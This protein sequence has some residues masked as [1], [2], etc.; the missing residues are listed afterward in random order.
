MGIILSSRCRYNDSVKTRVHCKQVAAVSGVRSMVHCNPHRQVWSPS[1]PPG[2]AG[3]LITPLPVWSFVLHESTT[4]SS[5]RPQLPPKT[6]DY[7]RDKKT[8]SHPSSEVKKCQV[9][10]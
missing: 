10:Q 5:S 2:Q 4:T 1:R 6:C 8:S 9:I 7:H 3:I